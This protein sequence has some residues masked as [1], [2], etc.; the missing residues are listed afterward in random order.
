MKKL[1]ERKKGF[2]GKFIRDQDLEFKI[3]ARR[4]KYLGVWAAERLRITGD[5]V[6]EYCKEVIK[7]DLEEAGD[8]D[9]FRKVR[10]DFDEKSIAITDEQLRQNMDQFLLQAKEEIIGKDS[11]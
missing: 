8:M 6:A 11:I 3:L 7:A 1:D 2:E 5:A 4:N 9:V 10:L